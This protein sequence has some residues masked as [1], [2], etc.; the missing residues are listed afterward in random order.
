MWE[1][2]VIELLTY[3]LPFAD[4]YLHC[5]DDRK[6]VFKQLCFHIFIYLLGY[7]RGMGALHL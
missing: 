1:F 7:W 5:L 4:I 3:S 2:L 6:S